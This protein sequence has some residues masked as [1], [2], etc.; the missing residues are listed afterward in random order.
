VNGK[1][2]KEE[3]EQVCYWCDAPIYFVYEG[4][5]VCTKEQKWTVTKDVTENEKRQPASLTLP[6]LGSDLS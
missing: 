5:A 4:G 3:P 6:L 1:K 2:E